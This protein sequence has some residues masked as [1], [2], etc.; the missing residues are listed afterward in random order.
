MS[1][2]GTFPTGLYTA[3]MAYSDDPSII[4]A[5]GSPGM[6]AMMKLK[7]EPSPAEFAWVAR[8]QALHVRAEAMFAELNVLEP[9]P[10]KEQ[11]MSG[12]AVAFPEWAGSGWQ[13]VLLYMWAQGFEDALLEGEAYVAA[14]KGA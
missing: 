3:L 13:E 2:G 7:Q 9:T 12:E 6:R 5:Q 14:K 10:T 4:P 11:L 1:S 8:Q